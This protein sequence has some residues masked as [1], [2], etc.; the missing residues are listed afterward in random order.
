LELKDGE[1]DGYVSIGV[2]EHFLEGYDA[3]IAEI[4]RTLR[5]GGFI[6]ITF[7]Y[8]SPLRRLR[9]K[10]GQYPFWTINDVRLRSEQFYQF[11]LSAKRVQQDLERRG[12]HMVESKPLDGIKGFK[13]ELRF[14]KPWLQEV[15]DRKR[16]GQTT[17]YIMDI[18]LR[19]FA[20]HTKLLVM[21]KI[22]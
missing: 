6:F 10:M 8:I 15:Y 7:P 9:V 5:V 1:L 2:I 16:G 22:S 21:Q 17:Y 19:L 18:L 4:A 11:A 13:D 3:I 14:F 20:G 12:F